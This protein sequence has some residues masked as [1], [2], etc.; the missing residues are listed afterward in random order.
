MRKCLLK[1]EV[2]NEFQ[3][4]I[5]RVHATLFFILTGIKTYINKKLDN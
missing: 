4:M 2:S 3:V 1:F 5:K